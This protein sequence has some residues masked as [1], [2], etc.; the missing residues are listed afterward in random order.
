MFE[1]SGAP[2]TSPRAQMLKEDIRRS[3]EEYQKAFDEL[4]RWNRCFALA[5]NAPGWL[6]V[7]R[8]DMLNQAHKVTG[9]AYPAN[10]RKAT[11]PTTKCQNSVPEKD[12]S[13]NKMGKP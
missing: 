13:F 9:K 1:I 10:I 5:N 12:A 11:R 2:C 3:V 4:S 8:L 7:P 6:D